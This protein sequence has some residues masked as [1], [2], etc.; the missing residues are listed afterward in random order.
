MQPPRSALSRAALAGL[1]AAAAGLVAA[2]ASAQE[3]VHRFINPSFG[4]NPF[5]SSHLLAIAQIDRPAEP[6][7]PAEPVPTE[8]ELIARQIR[9]RF[10][11]NLSSDIIQQIERAQPGQSGEFTFGNQRVSFTRTATETRITFTNIDT[12]VTDTITVPVRTGSSLFASTTPTPVSPAAALS[13]ERALGASVAS[14][15]GGMAYTST[16]NPGPVE[17]PVTGR[18]F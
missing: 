9:A 11:S 6:E 16:L 18:G 4:G 1:A 3:L 12:G 13:A 10:L 14:S 17:L 2:P 8:E 15:N 5:N 7:E